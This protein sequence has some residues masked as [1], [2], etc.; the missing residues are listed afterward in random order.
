QR[1]LGV[2]Q[3]GLA[4]ALVIASGL[5]GLSLWRILSQPLG[6][7]TQHRI[8]ATIILP[9][10]V[11]K[12]DAWTSLEP[13]LKKLPGIDSVAATDMIPFSQV[14]RDV[15]SA[16]P[17][18]AGKEVRPVAVEEPSVSTQFF[19]TMG[20]K[21]LAGRPFTAGEIANQAPVAIINSE[22]AKHF[23]GS[24]NKAMGQDLHLGKP[25]RIIGVTRNVIWQP[26]PDQ[27]NAGNVYVPWGSNQA[28]LLIV[29][30]KTYGPS[31]PL[32]KTFRDSIKRALP[33]SAV[34]L[35]G[36]LSNLVKGASVFRA[37][38]AGMVAAFAALALLLAALGVFAITAFI[39]R[40]RLGEYGIR[41][42]LGAS[43]LAL[44]RLGFRE[45]AW[46]LAIGLPLGLAG[47]YLLGRVIASALY[48]TPV[49][50]VGLYVAGIVII[51]AVVFAAA[52]GPARY[53]AR[54]PIRDLIGGGGA[55]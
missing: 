32:I 47:A 8:E 25:V 35:I 4:C 54:A 14:G 1:T 37:A 41:A 55:Q 34:M 28:G 39:A 26:T 3:I 38:G 30:A 7:A 18:D 6:F 23:F 40:A 48:Q 31:A 36:T 20:I 43:P 15:G 33:G 19:T 45:A 16:A 21:F 9:H 13:Q 42:A 10:N 22:L 17:V 46:L 44:L 51:A 5:L 27:Y 12:S 11:K 2:V 24:V 29:V 52:W 49:F 53:A 50:D